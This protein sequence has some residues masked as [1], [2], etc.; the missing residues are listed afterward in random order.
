MTGTVVADFNSDG[1]ADLATF[2]APD[3]NIHFGTGHGTFQAP[4]IYTVGPGS[5]LARSDL[6]EDGHVDLLVSGDGLTVL[7]NRGDGTF[8][9]SLS[10]PTLSYAELGDVDGDG[11]LDVLAGDFRG[12]LRVRMNEGRGALGAAIDSGS[13]TLVVGRTAVGDVDGDGKADIVYSGVNSQILLGRGNGTFAPSQNA[14]PLGDVFP[15]LAD[16]NGDGSLDIVIRS[17]GAAGLP[18]QVRILA[19]DGRGTF[20]QQAQ[21]AVPDGD[22]PA[23]AA[24]VNCDDRLDLV[25][26]G[27]GPVSVLI[28]LGDGTFGNAENYP[29]RPPLTIGDLNADGKPDLVTG[30]PGPPPAEATAFSN[31]LP[32]LGDGTFLAPGAFRFPIASPS[33]GPVF[34]GAMASGDLNGDGKLDF[35]VV[36]YYGAS[37]VTNISSSLIAVLLNGGTTGFGLA[38]KDYSLAM[39]S[40][41][42]ELAAG[43][44][45]GDGQPDLAL[46][47][48]ATTVPRI[49]VY[50]SRGAGVFANPLLTPI[51]TPFVLTQIAAGDLDGDGNVDL[52]TAGVGVNI[53]FNRGDATF[54]EPV[55]YDSPLPST[56][57]LRDLDGDGALDIVVTTGVG[58]NDARTLRNLGNRTFTPFI[59]FPSAD[60]TNAVAIEDVDGDGK[61]DLVTAGRAEVRVLRD[62]NNGSFAIDES[63]AAGANARLAVAVRDFDGDGKVDLAIA[64]PGLIEL[65]RNLGDGTFDHAVSYAAPGS[66]GL[67]SATDFDGDTREDIVTFGGQ[68]ALLRNNGCLP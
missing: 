61:A 67:M 49:E 42:Y 29:G 46:L 3:V 39:P 66:V 37:P 28:N 48:G 64:Q 22:T 47:N 32:N 38:A 4:V 53:W 6:N 23:L 34:T 14:A 5:V 13:P 58:R 52:V 56:I 26:S 54:S 44:L 15:M 43:D 31:V 8:T 60:Q 27:A 41:N 11:D 35:A 7:E 16:V 17:K 36:N 33:N 55:H 25:F 10:D 1:Y 50:L 20:K 9:I 59:G 30:W 57:T 68:V 62:F 45:N 19:N 65:L 40:S 63:Y 2:A 51:R 21:F 24:D 18:S 12:H